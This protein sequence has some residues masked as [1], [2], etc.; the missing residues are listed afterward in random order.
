MNYCFII[1]NEPSKAG[2]A[3]KIQA[4]IESLDTKIDFEIYKTTAQ[5]T[6]TQFFKSKSISR[7]L[8]GNLSLFN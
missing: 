8:H 6:A 3:D 7:R 4:Q 5:K 2:N 1:N